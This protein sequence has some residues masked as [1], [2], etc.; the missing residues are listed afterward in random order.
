[1][2]PF[3]NKGPKAQA[4]TGNN[5]RLPNLVDDIKSLVFLLRAALATRVITNHFFFFLL[6]S[7]LCFSQKV[8]LTIFEVFRDK[9]LLI[10]I[11]TK[12]SV[13]MSRF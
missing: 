2:H 10:H 7:F 12:R 13:L 8:S 11:Y 4:V 3:L 5:L 9:I 6:S 1:M